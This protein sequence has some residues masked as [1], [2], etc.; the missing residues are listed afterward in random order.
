VDHA[1]RDHKFFAGGRP[2]HLAVNFE[3]DLTVENHHDFID[4]VSIIIP[5]LTWRVGPDVAPKSARLPVL[6]NG[7]DVYHGGTIKHSIGA[8]S[9]EDRILKGSIRRRNEERLRLT[10]RR[11]A[12]AW[13]GGGEGNQPS[14]TPL[15]HFRIQGVAFAA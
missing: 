10:S 13:S 9:T 8:G 14:L 1:R 12:R 6:A 3:F 15:L 4:G 2:K 7:I 5:C 11:Y